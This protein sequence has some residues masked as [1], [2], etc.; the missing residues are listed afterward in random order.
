M[1][2]LVSIIDFLLKLIQSW[3]KKSI[4]D[5]PL[6]VEPLLVIPHPEEPPDYT[7][8]VDNVETHIVLAEWLTLYEVPAEFWECWKSAIDIQVYEIYPAYMLQWGVKQDWPSLAWESDGKRHIAIK[9]EYLNPGVLAHEQAHNS[10]ALLTETQKSQF[11]YLYTPLKDTDPLIKLL[12]SI[13]P[14]GLTS[15]VEAHAELYRFLG[16]DLPIELHEFYPK[17]L[18]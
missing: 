9:P 11:A 13:N 18:V 15:D 8:T 2:I 14:Y 7:R 6:V 12:Y 16:W 1:S 4:E 10:F 17:L 5:N 3:G